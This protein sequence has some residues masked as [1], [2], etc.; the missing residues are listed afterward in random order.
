MMGEA[1][2]PIRLAILGNPVKQSKSPVIHQQFA[3]Q[4]NLDLEYLAIECTVVDFPE[5]V[6]KL[7]ESGARGCNIT[8]PFKH[9]AWE[10]A[11]R[12]SARAERARAANT[13]VFEEKDDWFADTTDG[14][15]LIADLVRHQGRELPGSR[16]LIMGAGGATAGI[17]SDLLQEKP[18]EL[19]IGNRTEER[20]RHLADRFSNLGPVVSSSLKQLDNLAPFDIFINATSL[21]HIGKV[22]VLPDSLLVPGALCYD[23]NYGPAANPLREHCQA[24]GLAYRDGTGMLVEQAA[25]SFK[26]WTG[27]EPDTLPVLQALRK[28]H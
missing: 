14:R 24:R 7:A 21:G 27:L 20:A 18:A 28:D 19:V 4:F 1:K 16:I 9:E 11:H 8:A 12:T 5:Q 17:L 22:P 2:E 25:V 15:G 26:L 23:L 3:Q 10:A 6:Q 13:L